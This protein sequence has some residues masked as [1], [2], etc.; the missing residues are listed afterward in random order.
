MTT[1]HWSIRGYFCLRHLHVV[2]LN[3]QWFNFEHAVHSACL[4]MCCVGN[5]LCL[6]GHLAARHSW[7]LRCWVNSAYP[8]AVLPLTHQWAWCVCCLFSGRSL[9]IVLVSL[10]LPNTLVWSWW[11]AEYFW[12][13]V[14]VEVFIYLSDQTNFKSIVLVLAY[15][16]LVTLAFESVLEGHIVPLAASLSSLPSPL[17]SLKEGIAQMDTKIVEK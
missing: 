9:F 8:V 13:S 1:M 17:V 6:S 5:W 11:A 14:A 12:N 10:C 16:W 3:F 15:L 7:V 4:F 2:W